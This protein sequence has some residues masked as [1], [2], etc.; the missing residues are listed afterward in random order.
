MP[1]L[2]ES[3]DINAS[4]Q[5]I[6]AMVSD[7]PRMGEWSPENRGARWTRGAS[8][9]RVGAKFVGRNKFKKLVWWTQGRVVTADPGCEFTFAVS[10]GPIKIALWEYHLEPTDTG[11]R[12]TE[13]WTERRP[14][15][16]IPPL[17]M[18]FGEPRT[19][20]NSTGMRKTLENLKKA[21]EK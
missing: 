21:A 16:V 11:V 5:T 17:N 15:W 10:L 1:D 14:K 18:V 13:T 2:S 9:P 20:M 19:T 7:L 3:I 12:V 6:Y 4:A 8:G